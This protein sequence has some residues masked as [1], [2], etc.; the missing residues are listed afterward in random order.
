[1]SVHWKT[2]N[3]NAEQFQL[4]AKTYSTDSNWIIPIPRITVLVR[5]KIIDNLNNN[6]VSQGYCDGISNINLD[7][8]MT[9]GDCSLFI[10]V[11]NTG[12]GGTILNVWAKYLKLTYINF[13]LFPLLS[14][15]WM[16]FGSGNIMHVTG[17]LENLKFLMIYH[18]KTSGL[19]FSHAV[20]LEHI[21]VYGGSTFSDTL[22]F[23]NSHLLRDFYVD[24]YYN[25]FNVLDHPNLV[26]LSL[27]N[28]VDTN[29]LATIN[30]TNLPHLRTLTLYSILYQDL[31]ATTYDLSLLTKL[32]MKVKSVD[33]LNT[34]T[35]LTSLSLTIIQMTAL[36][37][38]CPI[39][40][41]VSITGISLTSLIFSS[42]SIKYLDVRDLKLIAEI[43]LRPLVNLQKF[44]KYYDAFNVL[45][46]IK[47]N[48]GLNTNITQFRS[49][50]ATRTV[51]VVVDNPNDANA[52]VAPYLPTV[53][54]KNWDGH[55]QFNYI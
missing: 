42:A 51:N 6:I 29:L 35:N 14:E 47:I 33:G 25:D 50:Y 15:L 19:N 53:W 55:N 10:N 39:V 18:L 30:N 23:S 22:D 24:N 48:N 40:E 2:Y 46:T 11:D 7:L 3:E 13:D 17:K 8:S 45:S 5:Y 1:M 43:D 27:A 20:K 34:L 21:R 52:E 37:V 36:D 9:S 38:N 16:P 44:N 28:N 49:L 32:T 26:N 4:F 31:D 41:S 54:V 12:N